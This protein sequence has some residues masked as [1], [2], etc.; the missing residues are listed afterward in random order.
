MP[1]FLRMRGLVSNL[2]RRDRVERELDDE[3]R[4]HL[5][6]L[7]D[8]KIAG[9]LSIEEAHRMA[10]IELGGVDQVKEQVRDVRIGAMIEQVWQDGRYAMR[11]MR[12]N[13]GFTAIAVT[14]LALGIGANTAIF[15]LVDG[16][17]LRPLPY[18]QPDRL[19]K[20]MQSQRQIGLDPWNLSQASFANFR[21]N[22]HSLEAVA[23]Y[24]N[25]GVNL[26][27]DGDPERIQVTNVTAD[28]FTVLGLPPVLGR[29]FRSEEDTPG[30]NGICVISY[31]F[32]QRRFAGDPRVVGR[33]INLNNIPTEVIGVMPNGFAF[34]RPATEVWMP[35]ALNPTRTAPYFLKGL[36]RL[37]PGVSS[38]EAEAETTG[39]LWNFARQH[40]DISESRV[41]LEEGSALKTLVTPLKDAIVGNTE[42]PLLI[43]L[44]AVGLVLLIACANV[45]NLL[46]ARATSRV[47]EIAVRFALGATSA[48]VARQLLT[49]SVLLAFIGAVGGMMLAWLGVRMLGRLPIDGIPRIEEVTVDGTV[50]AFTAGIA[51]LTG[52]LFGLM[53][54]LRA[55][56]MGMVAA[57]HEGGRGAT[58][59][60]RSNSALV[61]SQ[62][63]LS[64]ILL[65]GAGLLLKSFKRLESVDLGFNPEKM[66]TMFIS[67]PPQKYAKPEQTI[68]F[69]QTLIDRVRSLPGIRAAGLMTNLPFVGDGNSDG[70]IVEG[71]EPSEGSKA[72]QVQAQLMSMTPGSLQAMGIPLLRGRDFLETDRSDSP[73]VAV[74]DQTLARMYWPDGDAIG[75]RVETTGDLQWMTIVGVV[76]GI[77]QDDLAEKLQP[78]IYAP[79]AQSPTLRTQLVIRTDGAVNAASAAVRDEVQ[80]LD[81]DIPVY[82][83]RSMHEVVGRTLNSQRLTNMLLTAFSVLAMLLAAVGVY[84]TMSLYVGSRKNE[85]GIRMALGAKPGVLLRSVLREGMLLIAAGVAIG[86]GGALVLT[87]AIASLLF[88]VSPTDPVVFTGVPLLLVVVALIA[89]FVPA[90]RASRVDPMVALRHE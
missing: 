1:F 33:S 36:A 37:G 88:E 11:I 83:I 64:F 80:Q 67:V 82:S 51:L 44:C 72:E 6:M 32:W 50:L 30:R 10:R 90:R 9:G 7:I 48:R 21:D 61:A 40:P 18:Q 5:A 63:A 29:T 57:M 8:E 58:S 59:S 35:I 27:G 41:P 25:N 47:R 19:V 75:K 62:F 81:T 74:V 26:T 85:F 43:L 42:K 86:I 13:A 2:F 69:Y 39:L 79:L 34:P 53:P 14:T 70:F 78:H 46:L 60:R 65:V 89:C 54:A 28:F 12:K 68:Q 15:S 66:V 4:A 55:Y 76:R 3:V 77:K 20:L 16:I 52:L 84:G 22:S 73:P 45:A 71:H 17:L 87:R 23:A 49:E 24:A 56:K 31:G 38:S